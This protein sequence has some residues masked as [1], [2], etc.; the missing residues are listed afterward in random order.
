MGTSGRKESCPCGSG[1]AYQDCC[2]GEDILN[3]GR[4]GGAAFGRARDAGE[5]ADSR[6]FR[7]MMKSSDELEALC[8]LS[9]EHIYALLYEPFTSP[10]LITFNLEQTTF[11]DAAFFRLFT[12]LL[13][14]TASGDLKPTARGNLPVKFIN[15]AALWFYGEKEYRERK[16]LFSFRTELDFPVFHTVR[17]AAHMSGFIRKYNN[18]L[19]LTSS[20]SE[21]LER[22]M[23]GRAFFRIFEIYTTRFNW[24]YNDGCPD[25][26]IVQLTF[27][28][29]LY[30]LLRYG[31]RFRPASFYEDLFVAAF[32]EEVP[33]VPKVFLD[34]G[35]EMLKRCFSLRALSRFAHFFGFIEIADADNDRWIGRQKLKRTAFLCDWFRLTGLDVR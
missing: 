3:A 17:L 11:P 26:P 22:G 32:P 5:K 30:L 34:P 13:Q 12:Y 9:R 24:A 18:R 16:R 27:L 6:T 35:G 19:R 1:R 29:T 8:G 28:F 20:G 25:F 14:G 21:V 7:S 10:D 33:H 15:D 4:A 2:Y 23:N 31:N